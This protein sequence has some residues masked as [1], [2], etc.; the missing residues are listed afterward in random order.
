MPRFKKHTKYQQICTITKVKK[1][2]KFNRSEKKVAFDVIFL[3]YMTHVSNFRFNQPTL[4]LHTSKITDKNAIHFTVIII[5]FSSIH[6]DF[7]II[8]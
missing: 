8:L 3:E 6:L 2:Y 7:Y 1:K 4:N 5:I